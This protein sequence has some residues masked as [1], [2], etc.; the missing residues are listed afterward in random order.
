MTTRYLGR[1]V[2]SQPSYSNSTIVNPGG[3]TVE[4]TSR[5]IRFNIWLRSSSGRRPRRTR[6]NPEPCSKPS[7]SRMPQEVLE[8]A[9]GI[10]I[11]AERC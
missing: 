1:S 9:M 11:I 8:R 10:E 6:L 4:P 5:A 3:C 2:V 7:L